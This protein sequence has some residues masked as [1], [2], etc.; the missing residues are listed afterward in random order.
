M[1]SAHRPL[2]QFLKDH[3]TR[4]TDVVTHTRIGSSEEKIYGG[5]YHIPEK[6]YPELYRAYYQ[7]VFGQRKHPEYLTEKQ[8][9]IG[10]IAIDLDFRYSE[11]KRH[12]TNEHIMEFVELLM[13]CL[14]NLFTV[15]STFPIYVCEKPSVNNTGTVI[16]DGVHLIVG[17]NL[18]RRCKIMLQKRLLEGMPQIWG[19]LREHLAND[20]TSILD[21]GVLKGTTNWQLYGSRKPGHTAY[22]LTHVYQCGISG[23]DYEVA[24][25]SA[26]AFRADLSSKLIHLSVR[27]HSYDMPEL[28]SEHRA[29]Y[30]ALEPE[31]RIKKSLK[32]LDLADTSVPIDY[33]RIRTM[34]QMN[35]AI[36]R[37]TGGDNPKDAKKWEYK[38]IHDYTMI[39]PSEFYG[40]GSYDKWMCAG[41]AFLTHRVASSLCLLAPLRRGW[42]YHRLPNAPSKNPIS[43]AYLPITVSAA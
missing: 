20:D 41:W 13:Q 31:K 22:R 33:R 36:E 5:K 30:D 9:E 38:E 7:H 28:S 17:V 23:E 42:R 3:A 2:S 10:P 32:I 19:S 29:E 18:D 24:E 26:E 35:Q 37:E 15:S 39:L 6:A 4:N 40:P 27:Y 11:D 34:E 12:Y 8:L 25:E 21:E 14:D 16:K 43:G 1:S